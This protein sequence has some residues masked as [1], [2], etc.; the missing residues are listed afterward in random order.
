M[1]FSENSFPHRLTVSRLRTNSATPGI[2]SNKVNFLFLFFMYS[3]EST[4]FQRQI[5]SFKVI[6]IILG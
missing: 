5:S 6:G 4:Y 2:V 1:C 3:G